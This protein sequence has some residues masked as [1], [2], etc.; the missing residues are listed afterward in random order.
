MNTLSK[1]VCYLHFL[2]FNMLSFRTLCNSYKSLLRANQTIQSNEA[3]RQCHGCISII[4]I[5]LNAQLPPK[6][7]QVFTSFS[8]FDGGIYLIQGFQTNIVRFLGGLDPGEHYSTQLSNY[9]SWHYF[10]DDIYAR[11]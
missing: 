11:I 9:L 2:S 8:K 1:K 5:Q 6:F 3:E 4:I 7:F 10:C